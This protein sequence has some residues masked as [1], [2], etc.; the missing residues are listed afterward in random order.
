MESMSL[1]TWFSEWG[2]AATYHPSRCLLGVGSLS[3][4]METE[5]FIAKQHL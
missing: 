3:F 5:P 1:P 4:L 2:M